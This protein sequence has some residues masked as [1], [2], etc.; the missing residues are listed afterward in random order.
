MPACEAECTRCGASFPENEVLTVCSRCGGALLFRYDLGQ[1]KNTVSKDILKMRSDSF[2]KFMELL[3]ISSPE[4]MV[5]LEEPYTPVLPLQCDKASG[6]K[7]VFMKDDGRLPTGSFKARG[8]AVAVSKL[9]ELGVTRVAVPSAGNAA[10]AL[11]AYGGRAG[12]EVYAF[13]PKDV[14]DVILNECIFLDAKVFLVDGLIGDAGAIVARLASKQGW[15]NISTN[16]QPYR[17]EGYKAMAYELAEQFRWNPPD[18]IIFPTG[19]GEGVIGLWKGFKEMCELGWTEKMPRLIIVQSAGCAP[20]VEAFNSGR[21][22]V[23]KPW[24]K[25]NTIADGLKVPH[26]FASYLIF[27]ALKETDGMATAVEDA[28]ILSSMKSLL[29]AGVYACPEAAATL[30]A[31]EKLQSDGAF[32]QD[33]NVLLYLTGNATKYFGT[34]KTRRNQMP[35]LGRNADSLE[36][37]G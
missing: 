37:R 1:V 8:M 22:E 3:P 9:R 27:R 29:S 30:A 20:L 7:N 16:K 5:S 14:P 31:S 32:E 13:L 10:S 12:F 19:G 15:F 18:S 4:S 17:V 26:P 35:I 24:E 21:M 28:R 33:E 36:V 23:E 6:M 11:A 25:P 34:V 2:W